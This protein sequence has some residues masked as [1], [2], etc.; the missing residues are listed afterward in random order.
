[1]QR[2]RGA[3]EPKLD[4]RRDVHEPDSDVEVVPKSIISEVGIDAF[5]EDPLH[6]LL[7]HIAKVS[8]TNATK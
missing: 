7:N 5:S 4:P 3:A 6:Q 2:I 1:M 8:A